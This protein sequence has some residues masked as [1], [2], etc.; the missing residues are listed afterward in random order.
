M[1]RTISKRNIFIAL[2][3]KN[4]KETF[5]TLQ[6]RILSVLSWAWLGVG[7]GDGNIKHM[8]QHDTPNDLRKSDPYWRRV[9]TP[10]CAGPLL[11]DDLGLVRSGVECG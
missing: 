6:V 4:A 2:N 8:S 3:Y 5:V 9:R 11:S 10:P 7:G 1:E